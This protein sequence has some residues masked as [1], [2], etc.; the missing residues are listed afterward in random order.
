MQ[1]VRVGVDGSMNDAGYAFCTHE[2]VKYLLHIDYT[3]TGCFK[4]VAPNKH[5][6]ST[7]FFCLFEMALKFGTRAVRP[8]AKLLKFF[9]PQIVLFAVFGS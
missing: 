2:I 9:F 5:P 6:I 7:P 3:S 1:S 4:H 8:P